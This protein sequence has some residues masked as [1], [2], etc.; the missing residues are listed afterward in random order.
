MADAH[1]DEPAW[2]QR[3]WVLAA[4]GAAA[5]LSIHFILGE[6]SFGHTTSALDIA[7]AALIGSLAILVAFTL[8]RARWTWSLTFSG[9]AAVVIALIFY[10]NG[11][12][13]DWRTA[14]NWRALSGLLAVAIAAPLFQTARDAGARRFA[15]VEVHG[16]AWTNVVM[17]F[18]S[19]VFVGIVFLLAFLLAALFSLIKIKLLS[20]AL[21]EQW[22]IM[23]LIG[24]SLAAAVGVFRERDRIVRLLLNVVVAVLGVLAPVLAAGL[25]LFLLSLPFTG[26]SA[27]WEATR[28]TTPILLSCVVGALILANAVIGRSDDEES[29][30]PPLRW[31]ALGLAI[32]MLPLAI[33]AAISTG[34]RI[35]QYGFTPERLW[36]VVFVTV[37]L[38]YG[39]AY[40]IAVLRRRT[41]WA[42]AARRLNL[43]L[44]FG[45]CGLALFLALPI[46][47]FNA[48]ST[49]DQV[50]RLESGQ[51]SPEKF[52]WAALRFQFGDP[53]KAAAERLA[54][55]GN[56]AIRL[57]AANSL[58]AS[59]RWDM[60]ARQREARAV[61]SL[62]QRLKI[63]PAGAI[64]PDALRRKLVDWE[65]CDAS[66]ACVVMFDAAKNEAITVRRNC[67]PESIRAETVPGD[68]A[69]SIARVS[70]MSE[71]CDPKVVKLTLIGA[72][73]TTDR[74]GLD[75]EARKVWANAVSAAIEKGDVE[76]RTVQRRQIFIGGKPA[77]EVFE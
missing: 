55:S 63:V 6:N 32:A 7:F 18:A 59:D 52:D 68:G 42:P 2:P 29:R 14:E 36:A 60:E 64:L 13:D 25:I 22:F 49:R 1:N 73:W 72:E 3:P 53:G 58:K 38:A 54:K 57:A 19:W 75:A 15:Y 33:I 70:Q 37:A 21:N 43:G 48:I 23:T 46:T 66:G 10:W 35:A 69:K 40:L 74:L 50:A 9:V 5:G 31:G 77:G 65:V 47:S 24:A 12:P 16:H 44:G 17:W 20:D 45:L 30:F 67:D 76:V 41:A 8:E 4:I 39:A 56:A 26:L 71:N 28:S 61:D 34:S 11:A 51:V 62:D 27:L